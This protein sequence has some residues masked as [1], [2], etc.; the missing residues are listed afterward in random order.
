MAKEG[1]LAQVGLL[2]PLLALAIILV[3]F[4]IIIEG[5]SSGGVRDELTLG[6]ISTGSGCCES[7]VECLAG[8]KFE[9]GM[10][11]TRRIL[12]R[13]AITPFPNTIFIQGTQS[14]TSMTTHPCKG[15]IQA[16]FAM[17]PETHQYEQRHV[18]FQQGTGTRTTLHQAVD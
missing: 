10:E 8:D 7:I 1:I 5:G 11:A 18:P 9:L 3:F 12:A 17:P 16:R 13:S 15:N 2:L 4:L 14:Q 6:W